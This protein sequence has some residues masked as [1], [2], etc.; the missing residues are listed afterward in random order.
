MKHIHINVNPGEALRQ[1]KWLAGL[2]PEL[3]QQLEPHIRFHYVPIRQFA[4]RQ[5]SAGDAL[6]LLVAGRLQV[7]SFSEDGREVGMSSLEPGDCHGEVAVIDGLPRT[8]SLLALDNLTVVGLLPRAM[9]RELMTRH[10]Q[11]AERLMQRLCHQIRE[12]AKWRAALNAATA[13]T[14]IF[15][16]LQSQL[17]ANPA[18]QA[19]IENLPTQQVLAAM[20][21]VSRESVSRALQQLI[22]QGVVEKDRRRLIVR[23]PQALE[24]LA[25]EETDSA[26]R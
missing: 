16:V 15:A 2:A 6:V 25:H 20:A 22:R 26:A 17:V 21:N 10:P 4:V 14:R 18:G 1:Q 5:G 8:A 24:R 13:H 23:E 9:A 11:V 19:V 7:I 12:S 3:L